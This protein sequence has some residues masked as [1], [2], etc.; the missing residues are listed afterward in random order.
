MN[1]AHRDERGWKLLDHTADILMEVRGATLEEL[2]VNA[3]DGLTNLLSPRHA[4]SPEIV[5]EVAVDGDDR[6]QLLVNFL[7]E[8]LFHNQ[9][10][11]FVAARCEVT[12]PARTRLEARLHGR[13]AGV[14]E[15]RPDQEI[16]GVTYHDLSIRE[17]DGYS[18]HIVFDV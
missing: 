3:A 15:V 2:F 18:V 10:R 9:V 4:H 11:G 8:I 5:L 14:D 13:Y 1:A 12:F 17:Q 16:K 7:R 6:E